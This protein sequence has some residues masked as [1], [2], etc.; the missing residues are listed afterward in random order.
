[1]GRQKTQGVEH[2]QGALALGEIA[3][4]QEAGAPGRHKIDDLGAAGGH[5]GRRVAR[6][7]HGAHLVAMAVMRNGVRGKERIERQDCLDR[8]ITQHQPVEEILAQIPQFLAGTR[9]VAAEGTVVHRRPEQ[10]PPDRLSLEVQSQ[11]EGQAKK[12]EGEKESDVGAAATEIAAHRPPAG[13]RGDRQRPMGA[14]PEFARLQRDEAD[15]AVGDDGHRSGQ[16][17]AQGRWSDH[18]DR[19]RGLICRDEL[20]QMLQPFLGMTFGVGFEDQY[21]ASWRSVHEV[22]DKSRMAYER[23]AAD[24]GRLPSKNGSP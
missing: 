19:R 23:W 5:I 13:E 9:S 24:A 22:G 7:G 8:R 12:I 3:E 1:M 11:G 2:H 10:Y 20:G 17:G 15:T 14:Q 21:F 18:G 4:Q 16:R 6:I